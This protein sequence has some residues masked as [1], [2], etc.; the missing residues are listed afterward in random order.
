MSD[1]CDRVQNLVAGRRAW[2]ITL[3][4]FEATIEDFSNRELASLAAALLETN[5][6]KR[7]RLEQALLEYGE[8]TQGIA[9]GLNGLNKSQDGIE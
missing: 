2:T 4:Q 1:T 5:L 3:R 6:T 9:V 7:K 8:Q